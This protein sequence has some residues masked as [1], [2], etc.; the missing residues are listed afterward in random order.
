MRDYYMDGDDDHSKLT[1]GLEGRGVRPWSFHGRPALI[2]M[3]MQSFFIDDCSPAFLPS[4]PVIVPRLQRLVDGFRSKGLPVI[5]TVHRDA[6]GPMQRWWGR[7]LNAEW[8]Q[9]LAVKA[10]DDEEVLNKD[11]YDA[12]H[13]SALEALLR[14]RKVESIVVAGVCTHLCVESTARSAFCRGLQVVVPSDGTACHNAEH[15]RASLFN[16]AHGFAHIDSCEDILERLEACN[17]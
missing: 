5:F 1:E 6:G 11:V 2:I 7:D 15:H 4:A 3:D 13:D 12:F 14:D 8:T 16:L 9:E 10:M 17:D